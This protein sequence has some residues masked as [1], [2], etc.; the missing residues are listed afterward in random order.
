MYCNVY[1]FTMYWASFEWWDVCGT[2]V[3]VP[4]HPAQAHT[5]HYTLLHLH[6]SPRYSV[7]DV[8]PHTPG[9]M[10]VYWRRYTRILLC[11][12]QGWELPVPWYHVIYD[13]VSYDIY[14]CLMF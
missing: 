5:A 14:I 8:R 2:Y 3:L 10:R 4:K 1:E 13:G 12:T 6:M 7:P 9:V 11:V